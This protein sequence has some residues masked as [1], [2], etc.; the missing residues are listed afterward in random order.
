MVDRRAAP[1]AGVIAVALAT[2]SAAH[3]PN[4]SRQVGRRAARAAWARP[5]PRPRP[6]QSRP[7]AVRHRSAFRL[8]PP[9]KDT[10]AA[11]AY[12][13]R[14]PPLAEAIARAPFGAVLTS[15]AAA[16]RAVTHPPL[17]T[18]TGVAIALPR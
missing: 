15:R 18:V 9:D 2:R 12:A 8:P 13:P 10:E 11:L 3:Q 5:P 1:G 6:R 7:V 17:V 4:G 14:A 16:R